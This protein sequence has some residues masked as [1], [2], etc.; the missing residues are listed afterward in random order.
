MKEEI[1][2]VCNC[3]SPEVMLE[4]RTRKAGLDTA[5]QGE[6]VGMGRR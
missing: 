5:T 6:F 4:R 3:L 2:K 1:H